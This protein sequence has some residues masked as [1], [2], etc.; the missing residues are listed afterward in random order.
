MS[1]LSVCGKFVEWARQAVEE[2]DGLHTAELFTLIMEKT[3]ERPVAVFADGRKPTDNER[4]LIHL[5]AWREQEA[6]TRSQE[7]I[8]LR[9]IIDS[10]ALRCHSQSELLTKH[11][12][13]GGAA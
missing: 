13:K 8:R 6:I 7:I 3:G 9:G 2:W 4:H 10:L 12:E 5:L 1:D 11:A